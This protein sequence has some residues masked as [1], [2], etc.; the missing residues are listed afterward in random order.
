MRRTITIKELPKQRKER[1][2]IRAI[3]TPQQCDLNDF[4]YAK[5]GQ[6]VRS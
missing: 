6:K 2:S 3:N 5:Y 1:R 4:M